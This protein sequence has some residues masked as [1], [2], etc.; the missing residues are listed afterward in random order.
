MN[1]RAGYYSNSDF[2]AVAGPQAPP[3]HHQVQIHLI[4]APAHAQ[5]LPRQRGV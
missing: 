3:P 5:A 1:Q 2:T 4:Q